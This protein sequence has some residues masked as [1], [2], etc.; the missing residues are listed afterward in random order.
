MATMELIVTML[1]AYFLLGNF[2]MQGT[3]DISLTLLHK[4][5]PLMAFLDWLLF[6]P[7]GQMMR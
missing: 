4:V 5:I 2:T 6:D 7:K 1:I 3:A